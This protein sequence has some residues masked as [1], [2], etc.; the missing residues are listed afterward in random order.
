MC[1]TVQGRL[2]VNLKSFAA[3]DWLRHFNARGCDDLLRREGERIEG[4]T[5]RN[6]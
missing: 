1:K 5:I 3:I 6:C 4:R 2:I